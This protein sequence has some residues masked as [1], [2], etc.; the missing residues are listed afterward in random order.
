MSRWKPDARGRLEQAAYE[1]FRDRGY[2]QTTV[3]EIADHAGL[4]ERTFFRHFADKRE[5]LFGG[6]AIVQDAMLRALEDSSSTLPSIEAVRNA[7]CATARIMRGRR[8]LARERARVI[9]VHADLQERE[10]I[11]R[12]LLTTSLARGLQGRG[13]SEG[14]ANLAAEV[15]IAVFYVSFGRWLAEPGER[16]FEELVH[17]GFEELKVVSV[18]R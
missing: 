4:T 11:K 16:E 1:L 18:G 9:A 8:E 2:E 17:E 6:T 7:I 14:A 10:L 13:V 5:V 3:A 12:K 15:G